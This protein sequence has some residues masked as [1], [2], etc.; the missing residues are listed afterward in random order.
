MIPVAN[1]PGNWWGLLSKKNLKRLV[2]YKFCYEVT[3]TITKFDTVYIINSSKI[4]L[5]TICTIRIT[6]NCTFAII[7]IMLELKME[8]IQI[9]R[10]S[11]LDYL[12][13]V[14]IH[15]LLLHIFTNLHK[16][17]HINVSAR[18]S[19]LKLDYPTSFNPLKVRL[20]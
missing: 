17:S 20:G 7:N 11:P 10:V 2:C 18:S 12:F 5:F 13:K 6:T 8:H 3:G 9:Y 1:S 19:F 4:E 14:H 15:L 16:Q